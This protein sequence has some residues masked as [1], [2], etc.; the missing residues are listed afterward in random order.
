M[1]GVVEY[2]F[3]VVLQCAIFFIEVKGCLCLD[4]MRF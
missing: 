3:A 2:T 1:L 4:I